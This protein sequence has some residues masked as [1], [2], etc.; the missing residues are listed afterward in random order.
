[1]KIQILI[2]FFSIQPF[3]SEQIGRTNWQYPYPSIC[4]ILIHPIEH[5]S[6]L[7][8][9]TRLEPFTFVLVL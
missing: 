7:V 1:M 9:Q 5:V 2:V 3:P 8:V 6:S 4:I